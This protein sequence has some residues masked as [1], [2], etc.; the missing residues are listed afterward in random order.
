MINT[1]VILRSN[2]ESSPA[3]PLAAHPGR[4]HEWLSFLSRFTTN[5]YS[6][7]LLL[8]YL[9]LALVF[10][11][12]TGIFAVSRESFY[13]AFWEAIAGMRALLSAGLFVEHHQGQQHALQH[14]QAWLLL[15]ALFGRD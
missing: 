6:K 10:V 3:H 13:E 15:A 1:S 7:P 5:P 11:G 9:T 8:L 12:A 14:Q 4:T 2:K